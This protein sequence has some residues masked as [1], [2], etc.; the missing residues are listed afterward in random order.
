VKTQT[1]FSGK[2][3]QTKPLVVSEPT[4]PELRRSQARAFAALKDKQRVV[5]QAPTGWGKSLVIASLILHKL[6][7]NPDLRCVIAVPQTLI[8]RGFVR[9]WK[10]RI[11]G[12]LVDWV[13]QHNLCHRQAWQVADCGLARGQWLQ[14]IGNCAAKTARTVRPHQ[15]GTG[16]EETHT[17]A[18]G[19]GGREI[20]KEARHIA[21]AGLASSKRLP[22]ARCCHVLAPQ[23]VRARQTIEAKEAEEAF[24]TGMA[25]YR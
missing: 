13:V 11:A 6:L 12:R 4:R 14:R 2:W 23:A 19:L 9:D 25:A 5:L 21:G 1:L 17:K 16:S 10:L 15:T 8:A 22:V 7:R 20:G 24:T 18:V 3:V